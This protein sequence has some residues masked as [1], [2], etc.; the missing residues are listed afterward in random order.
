MPH[1]LFT[2]YFHELGFLAEEIR[3]NCEAIFAAT[4][5]PAGPP[6]TIVVSDDV[7]AKINAALSAAV[8]IRNLLGTGRPRGPNESQRA[9]KVRLERC[10]TLRQAVEGIQLEEMLRSAVRN[11]VE[12]FDGYLDKEIGRLSHQRATTW[13]AAFN[14]TFSHWEAMTPRPR[15]IRLYVSSNRRFYNFDASVSLDLLYEEACA[16]RERLVER[17]LFPADGAGGLL[18]PLPAS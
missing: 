16:L 8:R 7:H 18:I 1:I 10:A 11:S 13:A 3:K 9:Y 6:Y 2:V 4:S 15:P 17:G 12:H 14:M 5:V